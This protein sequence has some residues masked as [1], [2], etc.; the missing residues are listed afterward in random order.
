MCEKRAGT[1]CPAAFSSPHHSTHHAPL[2]RRAGGRAVETAGQSGTHCVWVGSAVLV[3]HESRALSLFTSGERERVAVRARTVV[4]GTGGVGGCAGDTEVL[5]AQMKRLKRLCVFST[6]QRARRGLF[7]LQ[8]HCAW[9][10]A[11]GRHQS[12]PSLASRIHSHALALPLGRAQH[13]RAPTF[14]PPASALSHAPRPPPPAPAA[15]TLVVTLQ[16]R[17]PSPPYRP[18]FG[19]VFPRPSFAVRA[20]PRRGL[21]RGPAPLA[22]LR[23][24]TTPHAIVGRVQTHVEWRARR[25]PVQRGRVTRAATRSARA[26][27]GGGAPL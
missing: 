8:T 11:L 17:R 22:G 19:A 16:R 3:E 18:S 23:A 27:A 9:A 5:F 26:R 6:A 14:Q 2:R 7:I 13:R 15:L 24:A 4:D 12:T 1:P 25:D 20:R 10:P 21:G